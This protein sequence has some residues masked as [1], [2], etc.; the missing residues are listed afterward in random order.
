MPFSK[1][2]DAELYAH[3]NS[4]NIDPNMLSENKDINGLIK[5]RQIKKVQ[6]TDKLGELPYEL[7]LMITFYLT[8][9]EIV[10]C[11]K[12]LSRQWR[13]YVK[14]SKLWELLD[15]VKQLSINERL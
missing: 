12:N 15:K 6:V 1:N 13:K 3:N 2:E 14:D 9:K 11:I 5:Q 4:E 7:Q 10:L 8:P